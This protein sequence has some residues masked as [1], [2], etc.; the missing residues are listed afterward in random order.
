MKLLDVAQKLKNASERK[1]ELK[2]QLNTLKQQVDE[3]ERQIMTVTDEERN[4]ERELNDT[5]RKT[6]FSTGQLNARE[7][8]KQAPKTRRTSKGSNTKQN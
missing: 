8:T 1:S 2:T 4:L 6:Q 7:Y 3:L 5:A